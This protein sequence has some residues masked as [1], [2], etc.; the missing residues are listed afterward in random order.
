M[1]R[2]ARVFQVDPLHPGTAMQRQA[3]VDALVYDVGSKYDYLNLRLAR[4]V[5][6]VR[7]FI[8]LGFWPDMLHP[9]L[10][11]PAEIRFNDKIDV[12][13]IKWFA[14][15]AMGHLVE[16]YLLTAEDKQWF[17]TAAGRP[18]WGMLT[19]EIFADAVRDWKNGTGWQT[20]DPILLPA[21]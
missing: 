8:S 6:K 5:K 7:P 14:P 15:H 13:G 19:Q 18:D 12:A 17:M 2:F 10:P 20:L 4:A 16:Y 1:Q 9:D 3:L 21:A 11:G